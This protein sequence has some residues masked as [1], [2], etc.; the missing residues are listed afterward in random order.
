M[1]YQYFVESRWQDVLNSGHEN[2]KLK[3]NKVA[4]QWDELAH[5]AIIS[6]HTKTSPII[7]AKR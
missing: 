4:K 5:R 7:Q 1:S 6:T 3:I 2:K